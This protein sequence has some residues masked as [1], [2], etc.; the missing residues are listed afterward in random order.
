MAFMLIANQFECSLT[1]L[2][3]FQHP[4]WHHLL[5]HFKERDCLVEGPLNNLKISMTQFSKP[6]KAHNPDERFFNGQAHA[7]DAREMFARP[8][9]ASAG[10]CPDTL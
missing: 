1:L 2:P 6:R 10:T 9:L 8:P 7:I 3:C 4:L 5:L